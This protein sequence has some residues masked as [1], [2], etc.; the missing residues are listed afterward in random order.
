MRSGFF[1]TLIFLAGVG[2]GTM[3]LRAWQKTKPFHLTSSTEPWSTTRRELL[4]LT[5]G[6]KVILLGDSLT[7]Q[8]PW[9]EILPC[10][11]ANFGI[12]GDTSESILNRIDDVISAKPS[13]VFLMIGANDIGFRTPPNDTAKN[14]VKIANR[15]SR[16][17][18]PLTIHPVLPILGA[19]LK[20]QQLN[21]IVI[22]AVGGLASIVPIPIQMTD[23]NDGLHLKAS[24]FKKWREAILP[25]V[26][27]FCPY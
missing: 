8:A 1:I 18:I 15:L 10:R 22:G 11:V 6:S 5:T 20:V 13:A 2:S 23:L 7:E 24:G 27:Q 16:A 3:A 25:K 12:S 4:K 26:A 9:A 17:S 21:Q 14:I 19:E